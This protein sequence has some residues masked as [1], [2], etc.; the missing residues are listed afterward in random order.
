MGFFSRLKN[1]VAGK[2]NRALDGLEE[3]NMRAVVEQEVDNMKEEYRAA[4]RAVNRSITLVKK[5]EN[6]RDKAKEQ[7]EHWET[8]AKEAMKEDREDLARK[9]L[10]RKQDAEDDYQEYQKQLKSRR[11]TAEKHKEK[12]KNLEQKIKEAEER[13]EELIAEAENAKTTKE[14]NET[15]SGLGQENASENLNRLESKVEDLKAQAEASDELQTE[16]ADG[17]DDLEA[18]FDQLGTSSVDDQLDQ[19][20][21]E[22]KEDGQLKDD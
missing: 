16:L 2:A 13:K 15:L 6:K 11:Q 12:L 8:K 1:L 9:A 14:I 20:R 22:V 5:S 19:L 17:E 18:E 3:N 4:K 21:Q 7:L 10:Q